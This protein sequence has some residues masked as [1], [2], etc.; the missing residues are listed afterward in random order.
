ML[1][2][3]Q[4]KADGR[5]RRGNDVRRRDEILISSHSFSASIRV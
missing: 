3:A 5:S 4:P 2:M 1:E